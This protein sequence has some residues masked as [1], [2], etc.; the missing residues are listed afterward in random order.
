MAHRESLILHEGNTETIR[1]TITPDDPTDDLTAVTGLEIVI[2]R[3][4]SQDDSDPAVTTLS[5]TA[6]TITIASKA[7][8]RIQAT[9]TIPPSC[10]AS[11][12]SRWWRCDALVG[13]ARRTAAYGPVDIVN[14]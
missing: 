2:K 11:P 5:T 8:G 13:S 10:T 4:Q 6:G 3:D 1:L 12:G 14:L 9:A 7:K